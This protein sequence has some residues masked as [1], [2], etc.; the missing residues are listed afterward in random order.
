LKNI[1]LRGTK[2]A[3]IDQNK[4]PHQLVYVETDDYLVVADNIKRLSIRGAPA[5][6]V[7]AALAIATS[8]FQLK[9][10]ELVRIKEEFFK[11]CDYMAVVRPTA[12]N[13]SWAVQRMRTRVNNSKIKT[14]EEFKEI[15]LNEAKKIM[16]DSEEESRQMGLYGSQL[17]PDGSRVLTNC[18][19]GMLCAVS[20][21][22]A[23]AAWYVAIEQGKH[24]EVIACE[25][26]PLLQGARLTAWECIQ[27]HIPVT[28]CTDSMAGYVMAQGMA[29]M[30]MLGAD[31]IAANGDTANKI[32]TYM[33]AQ[34]A[35]A[36]RIPFYVVA[37][38]S[39][40]DLSIDTGKQIIIEQRNPDE[41]T[42]F[43]GKRIAPE[44]V[45]VLNP[46]FD[47]TSGDLITAIITEKGIIQAP[48]T[49]G[50]IAE[51]CKGKSQLLSS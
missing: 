20:Y 37:P 8:I 49:S 39:T 18:N 40:F 30:V 43:E 41:V 13:L 1:E 7:S 34:L 31:R 23:A 42:H 2:V 5:I 17:I 9:E 21:G 29:N 35:H 4:L 11:I 48:F 32:G 26:R 27:N 15:V 46:A 16:E 51:H 3:F 6:G 10:K 50:K 19:D 47:V 24:V 12:V 33:L 45:K 28:L 38:I 14:V 44:G 36:H 22:T 25:T